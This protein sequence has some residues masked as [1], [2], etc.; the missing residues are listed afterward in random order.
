M[1]LRNWSTVGSSLQSDKYK[2]KHVATD[3]KMRKKKNEQELLFKTKLCWFNDHHPQGCPRLS[4]LCPYAHGKDELR[5]RP[6]F[7]NHD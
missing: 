6:D 7:K 4:I 5:Q 1:S 2:K 3:F